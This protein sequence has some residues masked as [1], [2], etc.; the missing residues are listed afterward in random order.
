MNRVITAEREQ[1]LFRERRVDDT[2]ISLAER[3]VNTEIQNVYSTPK[4]QNI[5]QSHNEKFR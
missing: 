1:A 3:I 5:S 4:Q 2:A